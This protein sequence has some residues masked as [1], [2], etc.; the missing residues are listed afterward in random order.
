MKRPSKH[1]SVREGLNSVRVGSVH[2]EAD[3]FTTD[4]PSVIEALGAH[5]D[6]V[7]KPAKAKPAGEGE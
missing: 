3:G 5:P 1:F 6:L 2:V 4:D 7:A